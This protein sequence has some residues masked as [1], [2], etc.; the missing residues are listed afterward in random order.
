MSSVG[1]KMKNFSCCPIMHL[2][3]FLTPLRERRM[4]KARWKAKALSLSLVINVQRALNKSS[5]Q[6][7][8][9]VEGGKL[10]SALKLLT[11]STTLEN[12]NSTMKNIR[13]ARALSAGWQHMKVDFNHIKS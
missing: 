8:G 4:L 5:S 6:G 2:R 10:K 3:D 7:G 9:L 1:G 11:W 13:C 12:E